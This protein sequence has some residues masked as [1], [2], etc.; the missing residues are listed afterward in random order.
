M[1]SADR[2][3]PIIS[4]QSSKTDDATGGSTTD[5]KV[6]F[7]FGSN[8]AS[9]PS[10]FYSLPRLGFDVVVIPHLTVGGSIWIYTD[11]SCERERRPWERAVRPRAAISR[12]S[13]YWGF[14]PRIG[15]IFPLAGSVAVALAEGRN[16]VQ[17]RSAPAASPTRQHDQR[18]DHLA[19][20]PRPRGHVRHHALDTATSGSR[21]AR[22]AT[23]RSRAR[24]ARRARR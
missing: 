18:R 8:G 22:R 2:L 4:W 21:S 19:A 23:F 1:I 12:R 16:R 6:S 15:Y 11:L 9:L 10:T 24:P 3:L 7:A 13:T 5:S 20:R 14:Q 17:Q